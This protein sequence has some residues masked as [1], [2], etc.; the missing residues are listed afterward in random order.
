[1][2]Q[3]NTHHCLR[4]GPL[5]GQEGTQGFASQV[6]FLSYRCRTPRRE[7]RGDR[8]WEPDSD[9]N[10]WFKHPSRPN[11]RIQTQY[12]ILGC[13]SINI[14]R[15]IQPSNFKNWL[16]LQISSASR[17]YHPVVPFLSCPLKGKSVAKLGFRAEVD[18]QP[19]P[20]RG[21]CLA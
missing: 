21:P 9:S 13:L 5:G 7:S 16:A 4:P 8:E 20:G 19:L 6:S 10:V 1:M 11:I 3:Q 18:M 2:S 12:F 14:Q 17:G 15:H